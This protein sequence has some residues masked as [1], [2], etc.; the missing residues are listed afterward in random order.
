MIFLHVLVR[1]L[2]LF[3]KIAIKI[4]IS[5]AGALM[6]INVYSAQMEKS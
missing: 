1:Q 5:I 2:S 4:A 6:Q 3:Q